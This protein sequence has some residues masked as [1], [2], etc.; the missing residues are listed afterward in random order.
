MTG[1][2]FKNSKWCKEGATEEGR[3]K[4]KKSFQAW[5]SRVGNL[6]LLGK[7]KQLYEFFLSPKVG[8]EQK[9][10]VAGALLYLIS[11]LDLIP[12]FIPIV[13]WLDDIGVATFALNYIFA[14][15]EKLETDAAEEIAKPSE[16]TLSEQQVVDAEIIDESKMLDFRFS[17]ETLPVGPSLDLQKRLGEVSDIAHTLKAENCEVVC[18]NLERMVSGSRMYQVSVIGRY[19]TG[20]S[21]LLNSLLEKKLLPSKPVPTTKAVTYLLRG[22]S[23]SVGAEYEDGTLRLE[24][25]AEGVSVLDIYNDMTV[26]KAKSIMISLPDFPFPDLTLIDTPGIEDPDESVVQKTLEIVQQCDAVVLL[27]DANYQQGRREY[28]FIKSMMTTVSGRKL[29]VVINKCDGKSSEQCNEIKAKCCD[30]IKKCGAGTVEVFTLS[31]LERDEGFVAFR[32]ALFAG[33]RSGL[34][35]EVA[36]RAALEL[37]SYVSSLRSACSSLL[38][39]SREKIKDAEKQQKLSEERRRQALAGFDRQISALSKKIDGCKAQMRSDLANFISSLKSEARSAINASDYDTLKNTDAIASAINKKLAAFVDGQL[40]VVGKLARQELEK[41]GK[42]LQE[43]LKRIGID[44]PKQEKDMSGLSSVFFPATITVSYLLFGL[45]TTFVGTLI[46]AVLGRKCFED[47]IRRVIE[48]FGLPDA[49][50]RIADDV[51]SKLDVCER[52]VWEQLSA[53]VENV[54]EK[55]LAAVEERRFACLSPCMPVEA[56]VSVPLETIQDCRARLSAVL[57]E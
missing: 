51:S 27:I 11:P 5:T 26:G 35:S 41:A 44:V 45:S 30:E 34:R 8:G 54:R 21:T 25:V 33:L 14:T 47:A 10:I 22:N 29:Y 55:M 48:T 15:L 23:C 20:K 38:D 16:F 49:R 24:S 6:G 17:D 46:F 50:S 52:K 43:D 37:N 18:D 53:A 57:G 4:V 39:A 3:A 2:D 28:E 40:A 56:S 36:A 19:S 7:A 12:D 9:I 13:G 32:E 31:A 1:N 42:N